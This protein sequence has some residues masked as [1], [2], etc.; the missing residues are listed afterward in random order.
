MTNEDTTIQLTPNKFAVKLPVG[1]S[2]IKL[3]GNNKQALYYKYIDN[4]IERTKTTLLPSGKYTILF[5]TREASDEDWGK[6][7]G[8]ETHEY[9]GMVYRLFNDYVYQDCTLGDATASG[10]SLLRS[11]NLD[12]QGNYCII[13]KID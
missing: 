6:V 7:V 12:P 9:E 3:I 1:V 11:K 2:D 4:G 13:E 10:L 8:S 5:Q